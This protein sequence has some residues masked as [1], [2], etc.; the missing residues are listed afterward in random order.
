MIPDFKNTYGSTK[1]TD[2]TI[3]L[4]MAKIVEALLDWCYL[5]KDYLACLIDCLICFLELF[6]S[7]AFLA[8]L[9]DRESNNATYPIPK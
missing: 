1:Q 3:V 8:A 7:L 9:S 6:W 5:L 4:T 2:P